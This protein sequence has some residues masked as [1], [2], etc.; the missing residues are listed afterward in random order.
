MAI[1]GLDGPDQGS[2]TEAVPGEGEF[3]I[4]ADSVQETL[5]LET[6]GTASADLVTAGRIKEERFTSRD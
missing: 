2:L 6:S 5:V 1:V 4:T 3:G